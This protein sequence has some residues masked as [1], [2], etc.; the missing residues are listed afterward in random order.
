LTKAD[1]KM[2]KHNLINMSFTEKRD[3]KAYETLKRDGQRRRGDGK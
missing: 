1:K 2:N 3:N